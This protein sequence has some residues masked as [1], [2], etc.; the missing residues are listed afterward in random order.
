MDIAKKYTNEQVNTTAIDRF[1]DVLRRPDMSFNNKSFP[2]NESDNN[3]FIKC[4][5]DESAQKFCPQRWKAMQAWI[6]NSVE[7]SRMRMSDLHN[8]IKINQRLP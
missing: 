1:K 6:K 7:V 3:A 5:D 4:T 8:L 2:S